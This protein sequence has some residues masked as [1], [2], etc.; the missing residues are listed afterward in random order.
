MAAGV[1]PWIQGKPLIVKLW[2]PYILVPAECDAK[3][4]QEAGAS[5]GQRQTQG[6][7]RRSKQQKQ[8]EEQD[9]QWLGDKVRV[10]GILPSSLR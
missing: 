9:V 10:S 2:A 1:P 4:S 6:K 3:G 7:P 5:S 8:V